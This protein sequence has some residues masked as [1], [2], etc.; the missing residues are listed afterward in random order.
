MGL[1]AGARVARCPRCVRASRIRPAFAAQLRWAAPRP[2]ASRSLPADGGH[3]SCSQGRRPRPR[4]R[5]ALEPVNVVPPPRDPDPRS[6]RYRRKRRSTTHVHAH[7][8]GSVI[9]ATVQ[10]DAGRI[11]SAARQRLQH[12]DDNLSDRCFLVATLIEVSHDSAHCAYYCNRIPHCP[13]LG[14]VRA[15]IVGNDPHPT[16]SR[17]RH[18]VSKRDCMGGRGRTEVPYSLSRHPHVAVTR[19]FPAQAG[20][21]WGEGRYQQY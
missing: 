5:D 14:G 12:A 4:A 10:R 1:P 8:R 19:T 21:G 17:L 7:N 18:V 9:A 6:R 2:R 13:T 15:K 16:L 3:A 11:R 20:E